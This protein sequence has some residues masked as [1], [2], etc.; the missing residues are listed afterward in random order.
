MNKDFYKKLGLNIK[1]LRQEKNLTQQEL[2]D[3]I[4]K[5]L[6]FTGKIEIAFSKPHIDTLI[7][8]ANALDV[9][10]SELTNF[11]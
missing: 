1:K 5:G 7:D 2:A 4:G 3:K 8:I 11:K 9:T 6:N 10:V